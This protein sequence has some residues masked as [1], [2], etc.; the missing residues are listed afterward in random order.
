MARSV[1]AVDFDDVVSPQID[2]LIEF[3]NQRYG[4]NWTRDDFM[5]PG[6][7]WTYFQNLWGV[8]LDEGQR[9]FNE[10]LD[11]GFQFKQ[12]IAPDALTVLSDLKSDYRLEIVTS[13][14]S[15]Y[16]TETLKM[17]TAK[18]P[19][20]FAG[21]NFVDLWDQPGIKATK[22]KVCQEIGAGYLID[23]NPEHCNLAA[24]EGVKALLFGDFGW[25]KG[26]QL[27]DRVV[28][29][30]GWPAVKEFFDGERRL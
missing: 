17:I 7:Y 10:Y 26:K 5:A 29:V 3:S 14:N 23:D 15:R 13:R 22:A 20:L 1:I 12:L 21:V 30:A 6:D 2:G 18:A 19:G 9:R 28:K 16:Q 4:T 11:E 25:H 8:G 24:R 27:E